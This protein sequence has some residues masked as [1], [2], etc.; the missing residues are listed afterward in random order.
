MATDWA[1]LRRTADTQCDLLTRRQCLAAGLSPDAL[2]WR[3]RSRRWERLHEGVYLTR[4]GRTDWDS[5]AVAALLFTLSGGAV[6]DA[7]LGGDSAAYLWGLRAK[8]PT[9]LELVVPER[10]RVTAPPGVRIRRV[11]RFDAVVHD[12]AQPWRTTVA[13]TVLDVATTGSALDALSIV[14]R[15]V[16][17]GGVSTG[18]LR[19]ELLAR[20]GHRHSRVLRPALADVEDGVESGAELLYVRDVERAHGLPTAVRQSPGPGVRRDHEYTAYA[21]VVEVDGRLGH[22]QWS[23]RVRDGRRDRDLLT[24]GRGVVRVFFADVAVTPCETAVQVARILQ[25]NGWAGSP[26]RCRRAGC[27]VERA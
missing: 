20:G 16:Q 4:P 18:E 3:V 2:A 19:H 14:A 23:E 27:P 15:A 26:R 5:R 11:S 10:R 24:S 12:R 7:A 6:A 25:V 8:A 13:A 21:L 17:R 9:G 22:E 1:T